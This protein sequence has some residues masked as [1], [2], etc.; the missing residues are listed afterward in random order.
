[1]S[2]R[3]D[4]TGKR[5]DRWKVI[6][7]NPEKSKEMGKPYWDCICDCGTEKCVC[8]ENLKSRE[9]KSCGCLHKEIVFKIGKNNR[10]DI[11]D[12]IFHRLQAIVIDWYKTKETGKTYWFCQCECGEIVS[13][14][15]G[16]LRSGNT[17]SCGCL[18]REKTSERSKKYLGKNNPNYKGG[19]VI[20]TCKQCGKEF[21]VKLSKKDIAQFCGRDCYNKWMSE[22]NIG[23][24]SPSWKNGI[25][26]KHMQIRTSTKYTDFVETILKKADY[27]C[28]ISKEKGGDLQVH[29]KKGFAKIL[30][31]NNITTVK[32]AENCKELWDENNVVVLKEKWHSGIKTDNPNAFHKL[33]GKHNFTEEDFNNW[34]EEFKIEES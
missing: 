27:T 32:E 29:H 30:E 28:L 1:M 7:Y 23:E 4:L 9:S 5:F 31:E 6:R 13:V 34:F 14:F 17:K 16:N 18:N 33:Y 24:N 3:E 11:T 20:I 12:Q 2:R 15:I 10:L 25:T 21:K 19:K 26:S 8:G 22:N